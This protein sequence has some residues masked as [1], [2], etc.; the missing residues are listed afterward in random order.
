MVET[1]R[2]GGRSVTFR[3]EPGEGPSLVCIHGSA[4][5]HHVYDLLLDALPDRERYALNLP[6]RA[7]TEGPPLYATTDMASYVARLIDAEV[8]GEY[9]LMGHSLGGAV[10]IEHALRAPGELKG[11]VLLATGARLR[12]HPMILELFEQMAKSDRL[13]PTPPGLYERQTDPALIEQ[14][15]KRRALTPI[16][17]GGADWRAADG[18]DR[19]DD[20]GGIRAPTLIVAGSN[21][22]LTPTKYA[23]Y[24]AAHI[25]DAELHV[26]QGAGHMLL[27][28]RVDEIAPLIRAFIERTG[29][30]GPPAT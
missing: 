16:A 15:A 23:E 27:L 24:L 10:A 21:D 20:L 5:N 1:R 18:F 11:L 22:L 7:G 2:I 3:H 19:M 13:P 17:T 30:G 14:A 28:E 6:G 4:D 12:V 8:R 29:T 25:P 26:L 9:V